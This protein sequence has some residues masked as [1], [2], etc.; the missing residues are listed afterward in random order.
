MRI[1]SLGE[2]CALFSITPVTLW[3]WQCQANITPHID[4]S[5]ERRRFLTGPQLLQLAQQH[6][7]VLL[8]V[9]CEEH[10]EIITSL[11]AKV[12]HAVQRIADLE[13]LL[14]SLDKLSGQA[15]KG[16]F[17]EEV[18]RLK[19]DITNVPFV[20]PSPNKQKNTHSR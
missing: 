4:P 19:R 6:N 1:Y 11:R 10:A 12:T 5:D 9:D 8:L 3:R 7:R 17:Q 15:I 16:L 14:A 13:A 18:A 20:P 2:V